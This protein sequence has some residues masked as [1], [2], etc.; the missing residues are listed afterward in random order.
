MQMRSL[1]KSQLLHE[2]NKHRPQP[3]QTI[4][5]QKETRLTLPSCRA[6]QNFSILRP[7]Y[8]STTPSYSAIAKL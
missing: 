3:E 6:W 5:Q 8:M 4:E 2:S 7:H 1:W